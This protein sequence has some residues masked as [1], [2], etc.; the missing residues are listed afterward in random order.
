MYYLAGEAAAIAILHFNHTDKNST[1]LCVSVYPAETA[2]CQSVFQYQPRHQEVSHKKH[3]ELKQQG[4]RV[5]EGV[6]ESV[7]G[8]PRCWGPG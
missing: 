2:V 4:L 7:Y 8:S 3:R 5:C 1:C 6:W